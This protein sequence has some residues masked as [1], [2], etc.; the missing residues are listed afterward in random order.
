MRCQVGGVLFGPADEA[1]PAAAQDV[2][3][4][5]VHAG[6]AHGRRRRRGGSFPC[7]RTRAGRSSGGPGGSR[8]PRSPCGCRHARRSISA[9]A[10]TGCVWARS[11]RDGP[12]SSSMPASVAHSSRVASSRFIL[13]SASVQV[14]G[15]EPENW[16]TPSRIRPSRPTML[17]PRSRSELRSIERRCGVPMSWGDGRWRARTMSSSASYALVEDAGGVG[18]PEDVAAAVG[19]R[20]PDVLADGQRD[21]ATAAMDLL[22]ELDP[23]GRRPDDQHAAVVQI[24]GA[25]I[26]LR[27]HGRDRRRGARRRS[28]GRRRRCTRRWRDHGRAPPRHRGRC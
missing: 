4:E 10:A 13:R 15:N 9:G 20:H 26:R 14:L 23:G 22:G 18:P 21:V 28:A 17:T 3:P 5:H 25:A 1:R 19:A 24:V 2:E 16:A 27:G 11:A 8:W 7:G 6:R 12:T